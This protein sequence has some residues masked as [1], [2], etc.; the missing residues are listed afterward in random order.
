MSVDSSRESSLAD[1]ATP[2]KASEDAA[3]GGE[4]ESRPCDTFLD[5]FAT[6]MDHESMSKILAEQQH[7]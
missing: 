3:D 2:Q 1:A 4:S 7:M 5:R 6:M